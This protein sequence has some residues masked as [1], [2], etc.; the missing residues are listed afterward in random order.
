MENNRTYNSVRLTRA[1]GIVVGLI[2]II[3]EGIICTQ[4]INTKSLPAVW[5]IISLFGCIIVLDVLCVVEFCLVKTLKARIV[6]YSFDFVLLLFICVITGSSYLSALYCVI[7]TQLYFNVDDFKTKVIVFVTSCLLFALTYLLAW[8][9]KINV[10]NIVD[11]VFE[12]LVGI[13]IIAVHF[14]VVNFLLAF[15][16]NNVKLSKAIKEVDESKKE[17]EK[18]YEELSETAVLRERNRIAR[19]IHDNAGH[20]MTAVIMQTEA[21]KLLIDTNPEEAKNKIISA[22]IQAKNALEQMRESVHLLAGRS[23]AVSIKEEVGEIIAQTMDGT[24]VKIRF[25]IAD[26]Q[27]SGDRRRFICNSLKECFSNGIR[28][29]GASAFYVELAETDGKAVLTVSDNGEGL[30]EDFKEGYGLRG[31]REKAAAFGGG[32]VYESERGDGCEIKIAINL[33]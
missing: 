19:D 12:C 1:A 16:R 6:I 32:I 22:N 33:E 10:G 3:F 23:E 26:V 13:I 18:A 11:R 15:Y 8:C 7:L 29:G 5:K 31:I 9:F 20:S 27:L 4:F 17:L 2:L 25:D 21:A 14:V 30:P 28:H 24:D